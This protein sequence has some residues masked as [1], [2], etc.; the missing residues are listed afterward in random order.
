VTEE[1]PSQANVQRPE[2]LFRYFHPGHSRIFIEQKLWFSSASDFNDIFEAVP[3]FDQII[4]EMTEKARR[5]NYAFLPPEVGLNFSSYNARTK[6]FHHQVVESTHDEYPETFQRKFSLHAG[7]VCFSAHLD[8]LLMWGHYTDC[9]RGFVLEFDP[10]HA[11]FP[12]RD[13][14]KVRY[15]E[16]RPV[17]TVET[18]SEVLLFKSPEWR[19]ED[20]YRLVKQKAELTKGTRVRNGENIEGHYLR[21]PMDSIKAVYLGCRIEKNDRENL[22]KPLEAYPHIKRLFMR[23]NRVAYKLDVVPWDDWT[24]PSGVVESALNR[25]LGNFK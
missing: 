25:P 5:I 15:D 2:R 6:E 23:K 17:M 18:T 21:L 4:P 14:A 24:E 20:E 8:S 1:P 3:R 10:R 9:H 19:Y 11:L 22:I 13:F 16:N 12:P 7:I